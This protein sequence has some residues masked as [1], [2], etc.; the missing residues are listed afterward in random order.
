M[1]RHAVAHGAH[2]VGTAGQGEVGLQVLPDDAVQGG[3]LGPAAPVG[4][5]MGAG[6]RPGRWRGPPGLSLSG[7]GVCGHRRPLASR[8]AKRCVSTSAD[9][10][11]GLDS[12]V[13]AALHGRQTDVRGDRLYVLASVP[14]GPSGPFYDVFRKGGKLWRTF[15]TSAADSELVSPT[16]IDERAEEWGEG[17]PL[18]LARVR[19]EF[20]EEAE[21]TLF[22]LSDLEAAVGR[23]LEY[24]SDEAPMISFGVDIARFG[25]DRSAL[26]VWENNELVEVL[27]RRGLDTM[28]TA[29]W[30]AG[31]INR[32]KPARVMVDE[33]GVGSGVVDRLL[34]LGHTQ[35]EGVNVSRAASSPELFTNQRA[36]KYWRLREALE[37]GEVSLPEDEGLVAELSAVRFQYDSKGRVQIEKKEFQKKRVGHSPDLADAAVLGFPGGIPS[38]V[39]YGYEEVLDFS[40]PPDL[41][42][43]DIILPDNYPFG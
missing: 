40:G 19:G 26:A 13:V 3:G 14:G 32:R 16:W 22:R 18:F 24:P 2:G 11:K 5:G 20:P 10:A 9:E 36:Q 15:H 37:R 12:E 17:S 4:L 21:G 27:T 23:V 8:G 25:E 29:A 38:W 39:Q 43:D 34:Q 7:T 30:I 1:V 41:F 6:R 31:D 35:V 28:E 33:I 42:L